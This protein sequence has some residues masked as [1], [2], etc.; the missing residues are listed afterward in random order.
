MQEAGPY[1]F[2]ILR[3][4][5][6]KIH[7][8]TARSI[9]L[10]PRRSEVTAQYNIVILIVFGLFI[11][12]FWLFDDKDDS[13]L[14]IVLSTAAAL[15][16]VSVTI[17]TVYT[18]FS[19][20]WRVDLFEG[21]INL[22]YGF[23]RKQMMIADIVETRLEVVVTEFSSRGT[24]TTFYDQQFVFD[25]QNQK[26][27]KIMRGK[28]FP[29]WWMLPEALRH[30][31][32]ILLFEWKTEDVIQPTQ[33]G[34]GSIY[35][36]ES[37]LED[38]S[39]V[40]VQSLSDIQAWLQSCEYVR[41]Q[42]QFDKDDHWLKPSQFE[43]MKRGDCEDHALWAWAKLKS[44]NIPAEFV[45]GLQNPSGLG[46][47]SRKRSIN[48]AWLTLVKDGEL[49]VLETTA[50]TTKMLVPWELAQETYRPKYSV[51]HQLQTFRHQP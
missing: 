35:P 30:Q 10:G 2:M 42:M 28:D 13:S 1:K 29:E 50:K 33:F 37:Y 24:T 11:L 25:L 18:W 22:I 45:V 39:A 49:H 12:F 38:H 32:G 43:E 46:S 47:F 9:W 36:W 40:R 20:P 14:A 44:L 16:F 6:D 17:S 41:D 48:H 51:N 21:E 4:L 19:R 23:R 34:K 3:Q 15:A 5:Y 7:P 8:E 27:I 31:P 26:Q